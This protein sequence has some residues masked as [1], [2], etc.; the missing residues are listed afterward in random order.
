MPGYF[1]FNYFFAGEGGAGPGLVS[2]S[3]LE[4]SV[5]SQGYNAAQMALVPGLSGF[6]SELIRKHCNRYFNRRVYDGIYSI[7]PPSRAFLLRQFPVNRLVRC[8]T[9]AQEVIFISQADRT[10]NQQASVSL[11]QG[12]GSDIADVP[13]PVTGL[14][15]TRMASGVETVE[16]IDFMAAKTLDAVRVAV[17]AIGDG[18]TC[19]IT[20]GYEQWPTA[21]LRSGQGP[22]DALWQ[23]GSS[24]CLYT[25]TAP[26]TY[27]SNTGKCV[28]KPVRIGLE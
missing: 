24:F 11:R 7:E 19:K 1:D 6:A 14:D 12:A 26:V 13:S 2:E 10:T 18:W 25:A 28:L 22:T 27:D 5:A 16:T 15:L 9:E 17:G 21:D 3:L 20:P 8:L 23:D 4:S